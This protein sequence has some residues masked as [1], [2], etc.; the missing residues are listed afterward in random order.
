MEKKEDKEKDIYSEAATPGFK[1]GRLGRSKIDFCIMPNARGRHGYPVL[2]L[3]FPF[4]FL[5]S[6]NY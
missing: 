4:G 1:Y 5:M 6:I 2:Y 3:G